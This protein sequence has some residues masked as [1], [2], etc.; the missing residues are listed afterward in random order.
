MQTGLAF[1][2]YLKVGK[3]GESR[4]ANWLKRKGYSVLPVYEVEIDSGK[5][6]RLFNV[7]AEIIAPDLLAMKDRDNTFWVEAKHKSA[8]TWYRTAQRWE[9][10]I[11][12]R[13]Y[14]DYCTIEDKTPF[15]VYLLFLHEGGQAK[16]SPPD[17][18]SGL[19]GGSL[20]HLR[21]NESHRSEK[22]GAGGMV[23]WAHDVLKK[24]AE[25]DEL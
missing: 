15:N 2:N 13:H 10:G 3:V 4:I 9:T 22:W 8:F 14:Q 20:S 5:G 24:L 25:I 7:D 23:Y 1:Q 6:P 12:L 18:P 17:S 16:D 21:K 19:F 11:D